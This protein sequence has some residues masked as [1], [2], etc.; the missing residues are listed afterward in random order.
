MRAYISDAMEIPDVL[1]KAADE[2]SLTLHAPTAI[3][4]LHALMSVGY[5]AEEVLHLPYQ[6]ITWEY[7]AGL[8]RAGLLSFMSDDDRAMIEAARNH[9]KAI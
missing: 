8:E 3:V 9:G 4:L 5:S 1:I 2:R 6:R 7:Y